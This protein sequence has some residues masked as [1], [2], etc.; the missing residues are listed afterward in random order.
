[1]PAP[2]WAIS[3]LNEEGC[4]DL[5]QYY[6]T[7]V[8]GQGTKNRKTWWPRAQVSAAVGCCGTSEQV[9]P[10]L[11]TRLLVY[12][13]SVTLSLHPRAVGNS[14]DK[15]QSASAA[16]IVPQSLGLGAHRLCAKA[17]GP[18]TRLEPYLGY[19]DMG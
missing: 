4:Q 10:S 7:T 1:M 17:A 6:V 12:K 18:P 11:N 13:I 19:Q 3:P 2:L 16:A 5:T 15:A 9:S 8:R 14:T